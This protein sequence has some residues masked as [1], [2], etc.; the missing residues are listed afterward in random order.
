MDFN[1]DGDFTDAGEFGIATATTSTANGSIYQ[2][3]VN[4][5]MT[6]PGAYTNDVDKVYARV[7]AF[8]GGNGSAPLSVDEIMAGHTPVIGDVNGTFTNG[9]VEDYNAIFPAAPTAVSLLGTDTNTGSS[10]S[11]ILILAGVFAVLFI[12]GAGL[13][14]RARRN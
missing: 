12:T 4:I 5:P 6:L 2:T 7:R 8:D 10:G 14:V 1:D 13:F 11:L 3:T 9:E